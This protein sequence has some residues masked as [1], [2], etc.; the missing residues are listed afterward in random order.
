[1]NKKTKQD[2]AAEAA[3]SRGNTPAKQVIR[4]EFRSGRCVTTTVETR[5]VR[6]RSS[7]AMRGKTLSPGARMR[8]E[9]FYSRID[10][11]ISEYERELRRRAKKALRKE[12][13]RLRRLLKRQ[14]GRGQEVA[15]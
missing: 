7:S 13:L 12:K 4:T 10:W 6:F 8:T 1:M 14:E 2:I 9:Q 5:T 15:R 3:Y 11:D